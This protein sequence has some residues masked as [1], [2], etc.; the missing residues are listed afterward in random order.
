MVKKIFCLAVLVV[1]TIS[2][3]GCATVAQLDDAEARFNQAKSMGAE[4]KAPF[5]YYAAEAY[6]EWAR[7]ERVEGDGEQANIFAEETVKYA[8]QAIQ[9]SGGAK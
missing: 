4:Q 6:L 8:D 9:K 1:L 5:E 7:H 3:S 2:F